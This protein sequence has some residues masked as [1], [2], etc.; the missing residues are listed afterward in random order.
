MNRF[1][2]NDYAR[3]DSATFSS[4]FLIALRIVDLESGVMRAIPA[5]S[6]AIGESLE[7]VCDTV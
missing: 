7:I 4:P 5:T 6:N 1:E 3:A 2:R